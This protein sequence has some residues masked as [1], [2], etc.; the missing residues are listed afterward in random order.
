MVPYVFHISLGLPRS[1]SQDGI[2]YP[3]ISLGERTGRKNREGGRQDSLGEPAAQI[4][5]L[6]QESGK[7]DLLKASETNGKSKASLARLS[8]EEVATVS[9][10]HSVTCPEQWWRNLRDCSTRAL[11][12]LS[13]LRVK[14]CE[15]HLHS[16]YIFC[17]FSPVVYSVG[18]YCI[19]QMLRLHH[20]HRRASNKCDQRSQTS[21]S[22]HSSVLIMGF[23]LDSLGLYI[24]LS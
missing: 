17:S 4:W 15:V 6:R 2:K 14:M 13:S 20:G 9:F 21:W 18:T 8:Q 24:C 16:N 7:E 11:G 1:K 3:R 5:L 10:P 19:P 22:L 12:E 23:P